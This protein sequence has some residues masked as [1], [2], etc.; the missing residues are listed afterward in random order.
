M[1]KQIGHHPRLDAANELAV[2]PDIRP[3]L[4]V[5]VA[6][7]TDDLNAPGQIM[8]A[9]KTLDDLDVQAIAM[10]KARTAHAQSN[11]G[12]RYIHYDAPTDIL[13][14][15]IDKVNTI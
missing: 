11:D 8:L 14:L 5:P 1:G 7:A 4:A 9:Q 13:Y 12:L 10:G 6:Q 15:F 2:D 3:I